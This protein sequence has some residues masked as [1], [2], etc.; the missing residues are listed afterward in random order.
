MPAKELNS[1]SEL[2]SRGNDVLVLNFWADWCKPCEQLNPIFD[3]LADTYPNIHFL[4]VEA[5]KA[6]DITQKFEVTAVPT[7]LFLRNQAVFDKIEGANAPE[8]ASKV[9]KYN[10]VKE[11]HPAA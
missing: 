4:K 11:S 3:A 7:F 2:Q 6:E 10:Q 5:E 1:V 9:E 8:L